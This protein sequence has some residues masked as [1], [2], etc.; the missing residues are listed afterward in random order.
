M[1]LIVCKFGGSSL[2]DADMF[3]R[4]RRIIDADPDRRYIILSAPGRRFAADDKITDL[5]LQ[6]SGGKFCHQSIFSRIFRRY[7]SIRDRIAPEFD[8]EAEFEAFRG[9]MPLTADFILSR[10]EY[11]CARLFA[12]FMDWPFVD[13]ERLF[14]FSA[15]A[16]MKTSISVFSYI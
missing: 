2:C 7:A 13:A 10:G 4:V 15:I 5:L 8:L 11:L 6:I 14:F 16:F 3:L 9:N 1:S 12:A